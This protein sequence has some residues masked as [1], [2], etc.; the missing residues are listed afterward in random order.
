M[1]KFLTLFLCLF[2]FSHAW[3]T[4]PSA[5]LSQYDK[6]Y[7]HYGAYMLFVGQ[8]PIT[9]YYK[10]VPA[11]NAQST[12][13]QDNTLLNKTKK[14]VDAAKYISVIEDSIKG[15]PLE[16]RKFI[17]E[18]GRAEEFTDILPLLRDIEMKK[19]DKETEANI[20]FTFSNIKYLRCHQPKACGCAS[21]VSRQQHRIS[22][23]DPNLEVITD[24]DRRCM[25]IKTDVYSSVKA[26]AFHE[27]GHF[28]GL[29]D[30]YNMSNF[31]LIYS[32]SDRFNRN[33]IMGS[34]HKDITCDDVDGFIKLLDRVYY[35]ENKRYNER[36]SKGWKSFCNDGTTYRYGKVQNRAPLFT[37]WNLYRFT[38]QGNLAQ[39]IDQLPFATYDGAEVSRNAHGLMETLTSTADN[40]AIKYAYNLTGNNPTVNITAYSLKDNLKLAALQYQRSGEKEWQ[41]PVLTLS[42]S[43]R[44]CHFTAS[45]GS[46]KPWAW[47]D[48]YVDRAGKTLSLNKKMDIVNGYP[49]IIKIYDYKDGNY[50]CDYIR[51]GP[52]NTVAVK[53]YFEYSKTTGKMECIKQ[54]PEPKSPYWRDGLRLKIEACEDVLKTFDGKPL[55]KYIPAC[56]F[57]AEVEGYINKTE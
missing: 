28:Y 40:L 50:K 31:S 5:E 7:K 30:Q 14:E 34:S 27:A 51:M 47:L 53:T 39:T 1:R 4:S 16:V 25:A 35:K 20:I 57:F 17:K 24:L 48:I 55:E 10:V 33:S 32:N 41:S 49:M 26:V 19:V 22:V 52:N 3:A 9:Y 29:A 12:G 21:R 2:A 45:K 56:E 11:E 15:W 38:A 44:S 23:M 42:V 6:D 13:T 18:S 37:D 8:S 36:D 43:D 46:P 54:E